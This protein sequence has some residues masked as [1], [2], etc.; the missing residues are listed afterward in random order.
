MNLKNFIFTMSAVGLLASCTKDL[1]QSPKYGVTTDAL[2]KDEA[3]YKSSLAKIY[4]GFALTGNTGPDGSGDLGGIDEGFSSYLR[5][6]F[7][8]QELSTDEAW[9]HQPGN[10][11]AHD[12]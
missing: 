3:G 11:L 12:T 8:L 5:N 6:Y 4:G 7:N 2:Y 10:P 9:R 1:N